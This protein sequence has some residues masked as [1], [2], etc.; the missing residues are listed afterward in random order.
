[1]VSTLSAAIGL[2]G[3]NSASATSSEP[4]GRE[5][6]VTTPMKVVGFDAAVAEQHGYKIVT[7]PNGEQTSVP[8]DGHVAPHS[9]PVVHGDCGESYIHFYATGGHYDGE[10]NTGYK[11]DYSVVR[12]GWTV[13]VTDRFGLGKL[14]DSGWATGASHEMHFLTHSGGAGDA[15]AEVEGGSYVVMIDGEECHSGSPLGHNVLLQGLTAH[16]EK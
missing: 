9:I 6:T 7:L 3:A 4:K 11:V 2:A 15:T 10:V 13:D 16:S 12:Y 14:P 1:M 8:K 5:V